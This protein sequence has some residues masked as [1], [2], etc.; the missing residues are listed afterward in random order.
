MEASD[1]TAEYWGIPE[2][3]LG[4]QA[5]EFPVRWRKWGT[6]SRRADAEGRGFHLYCSDYKFAALWKHPDRLP[7]TGCRC[8]VE[9]NYSTSEGQPAVDALYDVYRKRVLSCR[10]GRQGVRI[11][12]DLNVSDRFAGMNLLGVPRGWGSYATRKHRYTTPEDLRGRWDLAR[13]HAGRDDILFIVFGGGR[14]VRDL[15]RDLGWHWHPEDSH[16]AR[17]LAKLPGE[18]G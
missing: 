17:G 11:F 5:R 8:A 7:R 6:S 3:D 16:L 1:L 9:V 12:V 13:F 14:M 10:W 2:L 18:G 15:C 4:W